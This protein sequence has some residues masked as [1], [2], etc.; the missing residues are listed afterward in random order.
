MALGCRC[1]L[2][3]RAVCHP[4]RA[5]SVPSAMGRYPQSG[6]TDRALGRLKPHCQL[7]ICTV[8]PD[9]TPDQRSNPS[10]SDRET[11]LMIGLMAH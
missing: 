1:R 7:G 4:R 11:R 9:T 5:K 10:A 6:T 3:F 8:R 2:T